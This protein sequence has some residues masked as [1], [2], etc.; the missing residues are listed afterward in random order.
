MVSRCLIWPVGYWPVSRR[1]ARDWQAKYGHGIVLLETFVGTERFEHGLSCGQLAGGGRDGW[2][3]PAGPAHLHSSARQNI[4][5][6]F[7][8]DATFGGTPSMRA[9]RIAAEFAG[10]PAGLIEYTCQLCM[11]S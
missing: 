3:H 9:E 2:A 4:L 8:C 10:N 6:L 1:L 11:S 5:S 7:R